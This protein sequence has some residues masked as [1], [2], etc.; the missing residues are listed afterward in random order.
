MSKLIRFGVSLNEELL[1]QFDTQINSKGYANRSEA[2]RDMIRNDLVE[3]EWEE[4]SKETFGTLTIV[5]DHHAG[6]LDKTLTEL[7]HR[8][9]E[10]IISNIHVL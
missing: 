3:K 5:Y 7:Q 4:G 2:I 6:N 10:L 9:Y 8:Y 1:E